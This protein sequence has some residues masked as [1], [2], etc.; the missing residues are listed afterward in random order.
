MNRLARMLV[1]VLALTAGSLLVVSP[2][3]AQSLTVPAT[4][5]PPIPPDTGTPPE[6]PPDT[7]T[8][9]PTGE[10][11]ETGGDPLPITRVALVLLVVG[12]TLV[13]VTV[14]RRRPAS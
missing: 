2:N 14:R 13:I 1:A 5:P 12:A 4:Y 8:P 7:T 10:L 3:A 6:V 11:P 9:P